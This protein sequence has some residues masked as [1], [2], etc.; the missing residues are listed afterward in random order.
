MSETDSTNPRTPSQQ[1]RIVD[2]PC[3]L[4]KRGDGR[5]RCWLLTHFIASE[6][7]ATDAGA[8]KLF[9]QIMQ[10]C[11]ED[12]TCTLAGSGFVLPFR[13]NEDEFGESPPSMEN[14]DFFLNC[15]D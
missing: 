5:C 11:D 7:G 10:K 3:R 14:E 13:H 6:G 12:K 15:A 1:G 4:A 9:R 2:Y 8:P